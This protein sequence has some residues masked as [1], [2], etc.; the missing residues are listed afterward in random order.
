MSIVTIIM[1]IFDSNEFDSENITLF[2]VPSAV[3]KN[4]VCIAADNCSNS[5]ALLRTILVQN[6]C[7]FSELLFKKV[8]FISSFKNIALQ[9]PTPLFRIPSEDK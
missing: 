4:T 5:K 6:H 7:K 8:H 3:P 9:I 2:H 1:M